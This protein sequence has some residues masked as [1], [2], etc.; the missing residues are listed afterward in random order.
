MKKLILSLSLII[1][2]P[3]KDFASHLLGGEIS[4]Q[5]MGT[6][7]Y[8]FKLKLYRDC[9][10]I[11]LSATDSLAV[12]GHP[13][14]CGIQLTTLSI[15]DLSPAGCGYNCTGGDPRSVEE[16][17]YTSAP[18]IVDGIPPAT[19]WIFSYS[20]CCRNSLDNLSGSSGGVLG[21]SVKS[22]MYP[23]QNQNTNPCFDSSPEFIEPP[24]SST[25]GYSYNYIPFAIDAE[26]DSVQYTFTSASDAPSSNC[27]SPFF[28]PTLNFSAPY[29]VSNQ[30]P[31][32]VNFNA[33]TGSLEINN[34]STIGNFATCSKVTSYKCGIKVAEIFRDVNFRFE[35]SI[36]INSGGINTPP[37]LTPPFIDLGTGLQTSFADTVF[38]GDTVLFNLQLSDYEINTSGN[39]FQNVTINLIGTQVGANGTN[40]AVCNTPPCLT[41]TGGFPTTAPVAVNKNCTWLTTNDHLGLN[42]PCVYMPNTYYFLAQYKDNV[43][44]TNASSA[45]IFSITVL[46]TVPRP[47]VSNSGGSLTVIATGYNYQWYANRFPVAGA[48]NQSHT[49]TFNASYQC[50]IIDPATGAGNYSERVLLNTLV[51]NLE[52]KYNL[53][54]YPNPT[55][56]NI[57]VQLNKVTG[58]NISLKMMN[59]VGQ[60]IYENNFKNN[61]EHLQHNINCKKIAN[62]NYKLL[63]DVDG[64]VQAKE[65]VILQ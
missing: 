14:L 65:V 44:P 12:N 60:L 22:I 19:G 55:T 52:S 45:N 24:H 38:A 31:G 39:P 28:A 43:C 4:W 25:I 48:T 32:I 57:T 20:N 3:A 54:V 47:V 30:L 11:S 2:F 15:T 51:D 27:T 7:E 35:A 62:G 18:I 40:S 41:A 46:P 33:S 61:N 56:E 53:V 50:R 36:P 17:I 49:P 10:G 59:S 21:F 16:I 37:N 13:T 42:Y 29:N 64:D 8:I 9:S 6:G 34:T 26:G 5:C 63:I 23:Y 1:L 58:K